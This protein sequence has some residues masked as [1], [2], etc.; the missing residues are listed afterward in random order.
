MYTEKDK[1]RMAIIKDVLEDKQLL[2]LGIEGRVKLFEQDEKAYFMKYGMMDHESFME[3]AEKQLG[4][5][6]PVAFLL[7]KRE[8]KRRWYKWQKEKEWKD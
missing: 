3:Y 6:Y 8:K 1:A 4:I 5:W 7:Y 2:L